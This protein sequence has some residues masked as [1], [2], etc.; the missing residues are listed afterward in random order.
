MDTAHQPHTYTHIYTHITSL[1]PD[2]APLCSQYS[3]PTL[4]LTWAPSL[5]SHAPHAPT[6][7]DALGRPNC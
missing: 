3:L 6:R 5:A 2:P 4:G 1:P 7:P